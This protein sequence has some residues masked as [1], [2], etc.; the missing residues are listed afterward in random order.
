MW[1]RWHLLGNASG[2]SPLELVRC[3]SYYAGTFEWTPE[4]FVSRLAGWFLSTATRQNKCALSLDT[5]NG[6]RKA[7]SVPSQ[8]PLPLSSGQ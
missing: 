5:E 3:S 1:D 8:P 6:R 4:A 7:E 2:K